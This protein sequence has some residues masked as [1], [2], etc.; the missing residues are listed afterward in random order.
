MF[1]ILT[2]V[3]LALLL[4]DGACG[5][6]GAYDD[7]EGADRAS[8]QSLKGGDQAQVLIMMMVL[9]VMLVMMVMMVMIV[10]MVMMVMMVV[11]GIDISM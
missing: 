4:Y 7:G 1:S 10:R 11:V 5:D 6:I 3:I 2:M 9:V 8:G